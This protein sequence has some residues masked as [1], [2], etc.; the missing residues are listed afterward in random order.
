MNPTRL[1]RLG[2]AA[3]GTGVAASAAYSAVT[4]ARYGHVD[5]ARHPSDELLDRFLPHPEVDEY[6]SL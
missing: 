6:H 2:G 5:P 3:L 1:L 4:W